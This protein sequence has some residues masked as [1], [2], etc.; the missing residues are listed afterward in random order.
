MP[1]AI[2][3][4]AT[5]TTINNLVCLMSDLPG[6]AEV[7]VGRTGR[8]NWG[9]DQQVVSAFTAL[10]IFVR[11]IYPVWLPEQGSVQA[12]IPQK[13]GMESVDRKFD[14]ITQ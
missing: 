8:L 13:L 2:V 6:R 9:E 5:A 14:E 1:T 11:Y 10:R 12:V 3:T 4:Q 7:R